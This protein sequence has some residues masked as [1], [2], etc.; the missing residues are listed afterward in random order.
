MIPFSE[1]WERIAKNAG[2]V[3]YTKKRIKFTYTVNEDTLITNRI[4]YILTRNEVMAAFRH[5]PLGGP[6]ELSGLV[7]G[8]SY[9]WAILH[10]KRIRQKDW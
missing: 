8:P 1:V 6:S 9:I 10:D 3:F 2:K 5:V 7:R 4:D